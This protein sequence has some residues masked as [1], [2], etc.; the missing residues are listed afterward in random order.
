VGESRKDGVRTQDRG[1]QPG[2]SGSGLWCWS[3]ASLL[4]RAV[5][6]AAP[7]CLSGI[8]ATVTVE[9]VASRCG[10]ARATLRVAAGVTVPD[11]FRVEPPPRDATHH[12]HSVS[13]PGIWRRMIALR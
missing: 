10:S 6:A 3:D 1:K 9:V 8:P 12:R 5:D 7:E 13:A 11:D 2:E 4:E